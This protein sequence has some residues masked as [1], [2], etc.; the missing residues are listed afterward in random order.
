MPFRLGITRSVRTMAGRLA[1]TRSKPSLGSEAVRISRPSRLS[2]LDSISRLPRLSSMITSESFDPGLLGSDMHSA[3]Q[4][5]YFGAQGG[6]PDRLG[7]VPGEA[8]GHGVLAVAIHGARG[9]RHH[10]R[11]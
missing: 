4:A 6:E 10:R 11:G 2:A 3:Y 9:Q 5:A 1:Y 7:D 8:R